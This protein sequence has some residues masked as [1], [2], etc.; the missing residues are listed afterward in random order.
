MQGHVRKRGKAS[1]EFIADIGMAAAQRCSGCSRRFWIE[2]RPKEACPKCGGAL[3]ET[4]ER[5]RSTKAGFATRKEAQAAMSKL[6]V[7]VEERSYVAPSK[8]TLREYLTKEWLPVTGP[9]SS[10]HFLC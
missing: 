2:R 10:V 5:R 9:H 6:L 4:E 8:L 1:W 7:S 3:I